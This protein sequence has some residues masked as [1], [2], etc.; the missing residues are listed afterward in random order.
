MSLNPPRMP[1]IPPLVHQLTNH[2][3]PTFSFALS[4]ASLMRSPMFAILDGW[5][6][7]VLVVVC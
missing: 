5:L 2:F 7:L 1:I 3:Q 4:K 6:W